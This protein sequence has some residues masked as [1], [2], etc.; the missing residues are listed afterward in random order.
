MLKRHLLTTMLAAIACAPSQEAVHVQLDV[1]LD[2]SGILPTRNDGDWVVEL[3]T[4]RIAVT[5]LQFTILGE[6][7]RASASLGG[8][9]ISRA[10]AHPGHYAGGD[11][12]GEL[13][14]DFILDWSAGVKLGTADLLAG[15]YQGMNFTFRAAVVADG[16]T[17]ADP[18]LGHTAHLTGRAL[19]GEQQIDFTAVLD[20]A[21]GTQMVGAPFEDTVQASRVSPIVVRFL[22]TD[23]VEGTSLFDGLDFAALD[24]D[25][26][27][28]VSIGPGDEAHNILRRTLQAH[29]HYSATLK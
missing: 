5:D 26:D 10:W 17:A 6:M 21:A 3:T 19:K 4:V 9:L 20:V 25:G 16:L 23:P 28:V 12:T 27:G 2:A 7:H 22:L 8:W 1:E 15:E 11:V 14:G 18:L 24:S 13:A 29:V